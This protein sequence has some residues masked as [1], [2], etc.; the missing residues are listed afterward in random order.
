MRLVFLRNGQTAAHLATLEALETIALTFQQ[1][2]PEQFE[3]QKAG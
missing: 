3:P 1:Y 2:Q